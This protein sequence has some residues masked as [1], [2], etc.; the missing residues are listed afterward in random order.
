MNI[1]ECSNC[2][3]ESRI[4]FRV[5]YTPTGRGYNLCSAYC[6]NDWA[7]GAEDGQIDLDDDAEDDDD[8]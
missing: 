7:A 2:Q 6:L 8:E 1:E 5:Q 4:I 3:E